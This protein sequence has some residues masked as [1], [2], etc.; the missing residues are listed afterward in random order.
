VHQQLRIAA[1]ESTFAL[2]EDLRDA[3]H[4]RRCRI[5][6]STVFF[7]RQDNAPCKRAS[8][9]TGIFDAHRRVN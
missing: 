9:G 8:L 1:T 2:L 5:H 4:H 3:R 7:T 6:A